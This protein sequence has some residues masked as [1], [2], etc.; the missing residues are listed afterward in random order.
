MSEQL[1]NDVMHALQKMREQ[2]DRIDQEILNLFNERLMVSETIG[3]LKYKHDIA[4]VQNNRFEQIIAAMV[5]QSEELN[6]SETFIRTYLGAMH[7]ESIR[8]QEEL[9][10]SLI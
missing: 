10:R 2:I 7:T 1:Q 3:L 4:V 8:R 6:I 5:E 9:Q